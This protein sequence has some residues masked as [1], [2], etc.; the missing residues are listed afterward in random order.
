MQA[1]PE[2]S[3][4]S[5]RP[6]WFLLFICITIA[7]GYYLHKLLTGGHLHENITLRLVIAGVAFAAFL[8]SFHPRLK[9][10]TTS[11]FQ[12]VL[13]A[14]THYGFYLATL[15][16]LEHSYALGVFIILAITTVSAESHLF[17]VIYVL[18]SAISAIAIPFVVQTPYINP[19]L[20]CGASLS[21]LASVYYI[22]ITRLNLTRQ[23]Q[24]TAQALRQATAAAQI[25][26]QAKGEFLARMS[27][28]IRTPLNGILPMV[29]LLRESSVTPEQSNYLRIIESSGELLRNIINDI[30]DLSKIEKGEITLEKIP[31]DLREIIE[32]I[33]ELNRVNA[34]SKNLRLHCLLPEGELFY[35]SDP[36]RLKQILNNL[37][38]N[39]IKFTISGN[40]TLSLNITPD[41]DNHDKLR[42]SVQDTGIGVPSDKQE[43]IFEAFTQAEGATSRRFGGTG[44][45]LAICRQLV[46]LM[47]G[48]IGVRSPV[49]AHH[50]SPGSEFFFYL[51][52]EK[53]QKTLQ[54]NKIEEKS[55]DIPIARETNILVVED[56]QVNRLILSKILEKSGVK[57]DETDSGLTA[58]ELCDLKKY[59]AIFMDIEMPGMNGYETTQKLKTE[60]KLNRTTPIICITAHAFSGDRERALAAGMD[61]YI[62]KPFTPQDVR[63]LLSKV[64]SK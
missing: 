54:S 25:A 45:G 59:D 52:L 60:S 38:N 47:G 35:I 12:L 64:L 7:G 26:A 41:D 40:I 48:Q 31:V 49:F 57:I 18:S 13:L 63:D 6:R 50:E 2:K 11:V 21:L 55:T 5:N 24:E 32:Y 43:Q 56:N 42:F 44:L 62:A 53:S 33:C 27:H 3:T 4:P 30:L 19:W 34:E 15:H 28:E 61:Y 39:A 22:T 29:H 16:H 17:L 37:V 8:L 20:F 10:Y 46:Q 58:I 23:L 51:R 1:K 14:V 9:Q 36:T